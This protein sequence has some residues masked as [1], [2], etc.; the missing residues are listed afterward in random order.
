MATLEEAYRAAI[1]LHQQGQA[2][3]AVRLYDE[4]LRFEPDHYGAL[5]L[6]GVLALQMGDTDQAIALIERSL[7]VEPQHGLALAN[8]GVAYRAARRFD[9]GIAALQKS[10][11][12]DPDNADAWANLGTALHTPVI[13]TKAWWRCAA[14]SRL[15]RG[16]PT[17]V[18]A[19][20]SCCCC[21]ASSARAGRNM[22]GGS[23]RAR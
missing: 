22:S 1:K 7:E 20:A 2:N 6:K 8:L 4:I 3:E 17:R 10:V 15:R 11:A 5:H 14:R 9:E 21:A 18:R 19:S 16:M 23:N 13:T 12:L